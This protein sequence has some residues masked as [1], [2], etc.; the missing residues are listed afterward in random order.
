MQ[1]ITV[2]AD[3]Q[4]E[5]GLSMML[6]GMGGLAG[7]FISGWFVKAL[8]IQRSMTIGFAT[9]AL[10]SFILFKSNN[11]FSGIIYFEIGIL[12]VFFGLNMGVLSSYI[13]QLFP[14]SVR[15]TA[16]GFSLNVG[17]L[18]TTIAVLSVGVLVSTFGGYG[19]ALLIFSMI[20]LFGLL[21]VLLI[22][23]KYKIAS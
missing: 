18:F 12:S 23:P 20:F 14:T 11:S 7:G 21:T 3:A 8:G 13:P 19:N 1:S 16:T 22:K 15:A 4:K 10:L 2:T 17:R 9:C 6:L 5:R